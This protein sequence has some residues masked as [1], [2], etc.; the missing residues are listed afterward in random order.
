MSEKIVLATGN[1]GKL[2]EI[3]DLMA[4]VAVELVSLNSFP[5]IEPVAETGT[6]F[7]ANA[8][9]KARYYADKTGMPALADD[10]GLAV[11]A[12]HGRPGVL[13]ARYG[14]EIDF[15]SK[16]ELLLH[17]L[18]ASG[19]NDRTAQF[20]CCMALARPGG[21]ILCI[22]NGV[23]DGVISDKPSGSNGFGY[24]PVFIPDGHHETFGELPAAVKADISHRRHAVD[25]IIRFLLNNMGVLT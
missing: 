6:T 8:V 14:G 25:I 10:S 1:E 4:G 12:L 19:S 24:D 5:P 18:S 22:A 3:A 23:C 9:L 16:I 7:E 15:P 2:A 13:S 21:D 17:E 11:A 20:V